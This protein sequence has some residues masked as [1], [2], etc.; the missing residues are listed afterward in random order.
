MAMLLQTLSAKLGIA[1][2]LNLAEQC[3]AHFSRP[4]VWGM[5]VLMELVAMATDLAEFLGAALGFNLLLGIP[6]WAAGILTAIV[7]FAMFIVHFFLAVVHPL[8]WQ[9]LVSMRYGVVSE[10]YAREHHAMW[11]Y[12]EKRARELWEQHKA[13]Q[14][15]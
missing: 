10:S 4:V 9:S 11:Y 1:S 8:M 13:E 6:P 2:G 7:T 5:W 14:E 12:G 3:R 15:E